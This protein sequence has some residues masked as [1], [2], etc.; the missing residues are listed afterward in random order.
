MGLRPRNSAAT[1]R[2]TRIAGFG[3][4]RLPAFCRAATAAPRMTAAVKEL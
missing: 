2:T 4:G 1:I 3:F